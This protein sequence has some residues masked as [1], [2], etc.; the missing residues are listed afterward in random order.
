[1]C[2]EFTWLTL[3]VGGTSHGRGAPTRQASLS[4]PVVSWC[5]RHTLILSWTDSRATS[6]SCYHLMLSG[7]EVCRCLSSQSLSCQGNIRGE[8][9][10]CCPAKLLS[11]GTAA[12]DG[13]H[14]SRTPGI[15]L[16]VTHSRRTSTAAPPFHLDRPGFS[17]ADTGVLMHKPAP[18]A[19]FPVTG[20]LVGRAPRWNPGTGHVWTPR[21]WVL[22][23]WPGDCSHV[24]P[25]P[26][27]LWT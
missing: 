9:S 13:T 14:S 11:S 5:P 21:L 20:T 4:C 3:L 25:R 26:L 8:G 15:A 23:R 16:P 1:M 22:R 19:C 10:W 12:S 17:P 6:H 18:N 2:L 24:P 7:L 27:C